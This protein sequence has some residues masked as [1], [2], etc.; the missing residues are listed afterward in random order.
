MDRD[1]GQTWSGLD[2]PPGVPSFHLLPFALWQARPSS[3][4][5]CLLVVLDFCCGYHSEMTRMH[6]SRS[7]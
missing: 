7:H 4:C 5:K 6:S 2:T 3:K 1:T